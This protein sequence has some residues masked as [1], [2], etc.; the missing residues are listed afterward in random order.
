MDIKILDND[1]IDNIRVEL[2]KIKGDPYSNT[3]N[4]HEG[5]DIVGYW[6]QGDSVLFR[7]S[8]EREGSIEDTVFCI[9][10]GFLKR[11]LEE[12][13]TMQE[14]RDKIENN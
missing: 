13:N 11:I 8:Q 2:G 7:R 10:R 3:P 5:V 14:A 9:S 12:D 4:W 1:D 6:P